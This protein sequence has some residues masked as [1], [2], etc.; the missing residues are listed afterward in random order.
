M[1]QSPPR[2]A[3]IF[4][5]GWEGHEPAKVAA[6]LADDLRAANF[7]P[8]VV[9]STEI[10]ADAEQMRT[11]DVIVPCWTTGKLSPEQ[12]AG[13]LTAVREGA[14]LAG[15]HGG[16]GDAF[17]GNID[18]E[19]M[20]GGH[21]VGHPHVGAYTVRKTAVAHPITDGTPE[22][23]AY[24]SEQ[25]YMMVDPVIT[26]LA[27]TIY[28]YEGRRAVMPVVWTKTW[29]AGRVFYSSLGHALS[30]FDESGPMR[31]IARRGL[32]WAA[33]GGES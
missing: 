31:Q 15:V 4:Q 9:D 17:R 21:F 22:E 18:Y 10:L 23:F 28:V 27:E 32:V 20:V 19:W 13:L 6:L 29:G 24:S 25:Y 16:M 7:D 3:L 30:E 14:G 2:R 33:R 26:V 12:S 5:G 11:F 1:K 8:L